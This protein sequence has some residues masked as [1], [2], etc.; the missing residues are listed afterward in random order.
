MWECGGCLLYHTRPYYHG[1]HATHCQ[2]NNSVYLSHGGTHHG[3]ND[4]QRLHLSR[5]RPQWRDRKEKFWNTS[6]TRLQY[7]QN[8]IYI[9]TIISL[10]SSTEH[11]LGISLGLF[12]FLFLH[13]NCYK[14][15]LKT[16]EYLRIVQGHLKRRIWTTSL[17]IWWLFLYRSRIAYYD[18]GSYL[19]L[20]TSET[21]EDYSFLC[22]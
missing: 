16:R 17:S 20:K 10:Q 13:S 15:R 2:G 8:P 5:R 7:S 4:S 12:L 3:T 22:E 21:V 1:Q 6:T 9:S 18:H 19:T 11:L 14:E